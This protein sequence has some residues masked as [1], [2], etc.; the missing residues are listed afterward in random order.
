M[1]HFIRQ[2]LTIKL[3]LY[4]EKKAKLNEQRLGKAG[5]G[6]KKSSL[7]SMPHGPQQGSTAI[8]N[9][10]HRE[11]ELYREQHGNRSTEF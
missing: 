3:I 4:K 9:A 8:P 11:L 7:P 1:N 10:C 2:S 5:A 6:K